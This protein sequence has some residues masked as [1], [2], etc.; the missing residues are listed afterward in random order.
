MPF[1]RKKRGELGLEEE[2]GVISEIPPSLDNIEESLLQNGFEPVTA[3]DYDS[4]HSIE[5][6]LVKVNGDARPFV[7]VGNRSREGNSWTS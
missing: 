4:D 6:I 1:L 7:K 2:A 5:E 3:E